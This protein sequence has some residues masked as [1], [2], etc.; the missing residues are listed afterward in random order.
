[1]TSIRTY[2]IGFALSIILTLVAFWKMS[3]HIASG[4][5]S[6]SHEV[7]IPTLTILA[8]LQLVVQL[9]FFLHIGRE[10]KPKWNL[11]A[12]LFAVLIVTIL[13]GG[14]LWIMRNLEHGQM[15]HTADELLK[16][17]LIPHSN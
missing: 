12:F 5:V 4:H 7:L 1:M 17:E 16:D 8:I 3:E 14:T 11:L 13:V 10:S 9:I 6:P 15:E 2:I